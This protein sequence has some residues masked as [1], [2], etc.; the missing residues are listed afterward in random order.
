[1]TVPLPAVPVASA[2]TGERLSA[3][4]QLVAAW[5]LSL[6][7]AHS[8]RAYA[9]DIGQWRGWLQDND[10]LF[11]AALRAHVDAFAH[12]LVT[13]GAARTSVARKVAAVSSFYIYAVDARVIDANPAARAWRPD[14][15]RDHSDTV[16]LDV[17][18]A[19]ALI[20]A[21]VADGPRS[22]AIV[23]L[24]LEVGLRVSEVATALV[25][26]LGSE[27]GHRT[28]TVTRKGGRRQRLALPPTT[29]GAVDV[30]TRGHTDGPIIRTRTGRPMATS[31]I[32]R[33]VR[34]L[35]RRAG[36]DKRVSPHSLRHTYTTLALDAGVA[37]RD[38]QTDLGHR[39]PRTT[40]RYD[41]GRERLDRS[42]AYRVAS[43][44]SAGLTPSS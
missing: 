34:R 22:E 2:V 12:L 40:R 21:A 1:M 44:L 16:A 19:R 30:V 20:A 17:G 23:R 5:L 6:G 11:L 36:I 24:L 28:T 7:S 25:A 8:A 14:I 32:Y 38:L 33:T 37:L 27:R 41:R 29:S 15:D 26:D 3:D 18:E 31:E 42:G 10:V 13:L 39:D 9:S 4:D 43:V 35:A